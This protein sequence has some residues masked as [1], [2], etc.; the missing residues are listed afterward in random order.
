MKAR[1][2]IVDDEKDMVELLS[3]NLRKHGYEVVAAHDGLEAQKRVRSFSPDLVLLD[4]MMAGMDGFTFCEFLRREPS[5]ADIPVIMITALSGQ[6]PRV[7]GLVVGAT[8]FVTKP[9]DVHNLMDR[10][11]LL[12]EAQQQTLRLKEMASDQEDPQSTAR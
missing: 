11:G 7:H 2:L 5:T 12:I 6:I 9:F 10:V 4:V 8:D 3:F 1:I